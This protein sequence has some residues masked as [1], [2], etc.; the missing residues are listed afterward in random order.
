MVYIN[1]QHFPTPS[2]VALSPT[3]LSLRAR[4][5]PYTQDFVRIMPLLHPTR[6]QHVHVMD[7]FLLRAVQLM[8][9][10]GPSAELR[11]LVLALLS[12]PNFDP[13]GPTYTTFMRPLLDVDTS[14]YDD[15]IKIVDW[16]HRHLGGMPVVLHLIGDG[17]SVLRLRDL[18]RKHPTSLQAHCGRQWAFPFNGPLSIRRLLDLG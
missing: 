5:G 1:G 15:L 14:S 8:V 11:D 4:C 13:G 18:K 6:M 3:A 2:A 9:P 12:R 10:L 17:Q 16:C 7:S